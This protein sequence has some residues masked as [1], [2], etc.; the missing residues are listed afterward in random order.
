MCILDNFRAHSEG[1]EQ[2]PDTRG[3]VGSIVQEVCGSTRRTP[4]APAEVQGWNQETH[5]R[6]KIES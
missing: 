2:S 6:K 4:P 5:H 1:V 3:E